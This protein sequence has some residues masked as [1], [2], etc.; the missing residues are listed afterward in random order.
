M[1]GQGAELDETYGG[2]Q[3]SES[4]LT[5]SI[6][7][8]VLYATTDGDEVARLLVDMEAEPMF[9]AVRIAQSKGVR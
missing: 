5:G 4:D 9:T 3:T 1:P 8:F 7:V 2:T 6:M